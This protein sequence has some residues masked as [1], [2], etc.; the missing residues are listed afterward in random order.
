MRPAPCRTLI[1]RLAR[2]SLTEHACSGRPARGVIGSRPSFGRVEGSLPGRGCGHSV[3]LVAAA[4]GP[5]EPH[6]KADSL[7]DPSCGGRVPTAERTMGPA[8]APSKR[9]RTVRLSGPFY[10]M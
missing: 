5:R 9:E 7:E 6:W 2:G 8:Q 4:R 10:E 3:G 1:P